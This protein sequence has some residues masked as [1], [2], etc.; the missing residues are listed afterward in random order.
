MVKG[1][2]IKLFVKDFKTA[3]I[4]AHKVNP[5]DYIW[6][7]K[8]RIETK[9]NQSKLKN[10]MLNPSF[11]NLV[12]D[13]RMLE[14][15]QTVLNCGIAEGSH[16]LLTSSEFVN[17]RVNK[18]KIPMEIIAAKP[19]IKVDKEPDQ[20][21]K[22]SNL[23]AKA[24]PMEVKIAAADWRKVGIESLKTAIAAAR[25]ENTSNEHNLLLAK[26]ELAG[27]EKYERLVNELETNIGKKKKVIMNI[28][29]SKA[30]QEK[31][32]QLTNI[33]KLEND[34]L[35]IKEQLAQMLVLNKVLNGKIL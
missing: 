26:G 13:G 35:R 12:K 7:I 33:S 6:Q 32:N 24:L 28:L 30:A 8:L 22:K 9:L 10:D 15:H 16:V 17:I 21:T 27:M 2:V 4:T 14:D 25:T 29:I 1:Y 34:D 31:E 11:Y 19:N 18:K 20:L 3:E 5:N 23:Q